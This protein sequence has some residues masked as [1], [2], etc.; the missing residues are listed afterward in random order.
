MAE[1]AV[2]WKEAVEKFLDAPPYYYDGI[3]MDIKITGYGR[4]AGSKVYPHVGKEEDSVSIPI[5]AMSA[6]APSARI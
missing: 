6:N 3:L 1:E 2:K 5:I 4:P